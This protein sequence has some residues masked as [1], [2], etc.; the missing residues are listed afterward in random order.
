[1]S[2]Q[3]TVES[4]YRINAI[5]HNFSNVLLFSFAVANTVVFFKL[6]ETSNNYHGVNV[7]AMAITSLVITIISFLTLSYSM[8]KLFTVNTKRVR[9]SNKITDQSRIETDESKEEKINR[10]LDISKRTKKR[11]DG[12]IGNSN[13]FS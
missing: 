11:N 7:N 3:I 9:D 6:R 4:D 10:N 1:M 8:Y 5:L 2:R 13:N 12:F